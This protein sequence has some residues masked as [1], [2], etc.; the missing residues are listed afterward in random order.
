MLKLYNTMTRTVE[1]FYPQEKNK[2]T[3]YSCGQTVY[4]ELHLGNAKTYANWDILYRTL[5]RHGYDVTHIQNFT[6]IG[7]LTDDGDGGEDKI[8]RR[9]AERN[10]HPMQLVEQQI[11]SYWKDMDALQIHRPDVAPR[12]SAYIPEMITLVEQLIS[13]KYAYIV[14][15]D[16]Y[17][18]VRKL[19][20]YGKLAQLQLDQL[21]PGH[22]IGINTKKKY[23]HDF[24]L[25]IKAPPDHIMHWNSPWSIGYP[26][27]HLEC[28]TM[29]LRYLGKT[30]DI[31]AGGV[32]HIPVHH[33]NEIAQS[34]AYND[35]PLANY[36]IHSEFITLN[37]KKMSKSTGNYI[38]ARN[39]IDKYGGA[40]VKFFLVSA[41]YRKTLDYTTASFEAI[42]NKFYAIKKTYLHFRR[43]SAQKPLT[44]KELKIELQNNSKEWINQLLKEKNAFLKALDNDMSTP[45][46]IAHLNAALTIMNKNYHN[47]QKETTLSVAILRN[48]LLQL[49]I[50]LEY[51]VNPRLELVI[52]G[53]DS[54]RNSLRK[55]K[56]YQYADQLRNLLEEAGI[57]VV[58][59]VNG[60]EWTY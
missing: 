43:K 14:D 16:V 35:A 34:E 58:D 30:V 24:S 39:L 40:A 17:F 20:N 52:K 13:K 28:S 7:H 32:D 25:W 51:E 53:I 38:T 29:A 22:R 56:Q 1:D 15:G 54:L 45:T 49:G 23:P 37:G 4:D 59:T 5:I 19:P 42:A 26:G 46:A 50:D 48:L 18:D 27:W 9:A 10:L 55:D 41:H 11:N 47:S 33:T 31:H 12:A 57:T 36:W 60:S 44:E 21:D 8:L 6:D 2:V 3:F